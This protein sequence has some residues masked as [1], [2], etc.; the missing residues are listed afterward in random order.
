MLILT[1]SAFVTAAGCVLLFAAIARRYHVL[2]GREGGVPLVGGIAIGL[3]CAVFGI[4]ASARNAAHPVFWHILP[5]AAVMLASGL[6]DDMRELSVQGKLCTQAAACILLLL[7]GVRTHIVFLSGPAN[8]IVTVIWVLA[9]T[10]AFNLLD[11]MDGLCAGVTILIAAGLAVICVLSGQSHIAAMLLVLIGAAGGFLMF[12][13]P[14][15][16]AYLGNAGSHFLG[17]VLAAVSISISY[18][19]AQ[20]RLALLAPVLIMGFP[21]F[22][23]LFVAFMRMKNGRSAVRKSK[24]HLALRFIKIGHSGRRALLTMLM[25]A[26]IFVAGGVIVGKTSD[27]VGAAVVSAMAV[28]LLVLTYK[29]KKV[30]IDG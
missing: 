16:K 26:C 14:P 19:T 8:M 29:M 22:D 10:N 4:I 11:I 6:W 23:T 21:I 3:V 24:D 15:A 20:R 30:R 9:I 28:Y 12:N 17:F 27:P 18:A 13:L 7:S 5:P 1:L 25:L 2:S